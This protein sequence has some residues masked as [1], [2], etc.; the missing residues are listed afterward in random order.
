[1]RPVGARFRT[2]GVEALARIYKQFA[3]EETGHDRLV[4]E[5]L[6]ALGI[7]ADACRPDRPRFRMHSSTRSQAATATPRRCPDVPGTS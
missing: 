1:M 4:L 3:D 2:R 6:E 5:D 7:R